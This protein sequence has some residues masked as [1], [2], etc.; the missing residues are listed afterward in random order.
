MPKIL[1]VEDAMALLKAWVKRFSDSGFKVL[2]AN[3]SQSA[4]KAAIEEHPDLVVLDL[5]YTQGQE[6]IKKLREYKWGNSVPV[7]FLNSWQDREIFVEY[8]IG[9]EDHLPYN[10]SLQEVVEKAKHKLALA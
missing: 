10:W 4:I 9:L 5:P 7:L 1:V 6:V 3:N 8:S 2:P